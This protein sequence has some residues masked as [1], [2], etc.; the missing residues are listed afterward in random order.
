MIEGV[1]G[2]N[3]QRFRWIDWLRLPPDW[4]RDGTVLEERYTVKS[5]TR[6]DISDISELSDLIP[7]I[8]GNNAEV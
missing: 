4:P 2:G 6:L 5:L 3:K 8:Q 1:G 7:L